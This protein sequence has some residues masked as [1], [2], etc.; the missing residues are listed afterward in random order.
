[1]LPLFGPV[2]S[3]LCCH[4][5]ENLYFLC[6]QFCVFFHFHRCFYAIAIPLQCHFHTTWNHTLKPREL[7]DK[8]RRLFA[9]CVSESG[10]HLRY[11]FSQSHDWHSS[12]WAHAAACIQHLQSRPDLILKF[13]VI[14]TPMMPSICHGAN[15]SLLP[16]SLNFHKDIR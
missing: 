4:L 2:K 13:D 15:R 14:I 8:S 6:A 5:G 3:N 1:M 7:C 9:F 11:N 12:G 16:E 10:G